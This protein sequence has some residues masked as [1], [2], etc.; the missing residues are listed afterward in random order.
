MANQE[1]KTKANTAS[2]GHKE[3]LVLLPK[4]AVQWLALL[5][6]IRQVPG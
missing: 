4:F 2:P 3:L 1:E 6:Y 5:F